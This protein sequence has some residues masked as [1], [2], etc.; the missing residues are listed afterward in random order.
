MSY[1]DIIDNPKMGEIQPC[2]YCGVVP[3][4]EVKDLLGKKAF[5]LKCNNLYCVTNADW[6]K[7]KEEIIERWNRGTA[8]R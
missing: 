3:K 5:V 1:L 8:L 6:A 7:S 2:R 4:L